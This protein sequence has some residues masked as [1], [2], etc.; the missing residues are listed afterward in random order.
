MSKTYQIVKSIINMI[1][2][3]N[4]QYYKMILIIAQIVKMSN[5]ILKIK[6]IV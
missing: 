2:L 1:E 6:M 4:S 5:C 3:K